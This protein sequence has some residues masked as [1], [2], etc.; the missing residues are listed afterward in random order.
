MTPARIKALREARGWSARQLAEALGMGND[1][2]VRHIEAGQREP[3]GAE[4]RLLEMLERGE[5]PARYLPAP[6]R[7]GRPPKEKG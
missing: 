6:V 7:R 4:V 5:L 2:R 3:T 1:R